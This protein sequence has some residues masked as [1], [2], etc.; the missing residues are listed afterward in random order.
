MC[1]LSSGVQDLSISYT[2]LLV[3]IFLIRHYTLIVSYSLFAFIWKDFRVK[4]VGTYV[5]YIVF[6]IFLFRIWECTFL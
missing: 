2:P 1:F 5:S 6:P 4:H 3:M